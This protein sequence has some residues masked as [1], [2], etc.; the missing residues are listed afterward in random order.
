[1]ANR[2]VLQFRSMIVSANRVM[3]PAFADL[4]ERAPEQ[5]RSVY[6]NSAE[7]MYY[8]AV[9]LFTMLAI[10]IPLISKVWIG[11]IEPFFIVATLILAISWF[12][13]SLSSPAYFAY[14]GLGRLKWTTLGHIFITLLAA[15]LG[16]FG[17][18]AFGGLGV[19][20]GSGFA[21]IFES[22]FIAIKYHTE[23]KTHGAFLWARP[24][25]SLMLASVFTMMISFWLYK[26]TLIQ[27]FSTS[28]IITTF[29]YIFL[30]MP[31]L[32]IHPMRKQLFS[33]LNF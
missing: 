26:T 8:I 29:V 20:V 5:I 33:W 17:G 4:V 28:V 1:M 19:L 16:W 18:R 7:L 30:I 10:F 27:A 3:V 12:F 24:N 25:L 32:W 21:L 13:N 31:I 9:P 15:I 6:L 2:L 14:L 11:F 23:T 22:V